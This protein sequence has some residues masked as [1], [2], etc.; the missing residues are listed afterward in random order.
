MYI[1]LVGRESVKTWVVQFIKAQKKWGRKEKAKGDKGQGCMMGG[2][3]GRGQEE[4]ETT[5]FIGSPGD[6]SDI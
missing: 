5:L 4:V 2:R 3:R 6:F 1:I